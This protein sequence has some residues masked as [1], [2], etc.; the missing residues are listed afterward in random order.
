[1][2]YNLQFQNMVANHNYQTFEQ[3]EN[4]L[5]EFTKVWVSKSRFIIRPPK[6]NLH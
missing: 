4:A 3:L 2:D 6:T 5:K 1:M